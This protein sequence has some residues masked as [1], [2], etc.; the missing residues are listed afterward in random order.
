M[1]PNQNNLLS[2]LA[3]S[4]I[5]IVAFFTVR[6]F[7]QSG[8]IVPSTNFQKP[9]ETATKTEDAS[10]QQQP[11][12]PYVFWQVEG[13]ECVSCVT[14]RKNLESVKPNLTDQIS[15]EV[16]NIL[17][18]PELG[19]QFEINVLP[20]ILVFDA[21]DQLVFRYDGSLDTNQ[22]MQLFTEMGVVKP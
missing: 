15:F 21:K 9:A 8:A 2:I 16:K 13:Q 5:F 12:P 3:I 19:K 14:L 17:D 11:V 22:L 1:E 4:A 7:I 20:T 6:Y 18:D 10:Q